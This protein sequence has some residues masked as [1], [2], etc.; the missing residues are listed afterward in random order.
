MPEEELLDRTHI[1]IAV[2]LNDGISLI[3]FHALVD[4]GATGYGFIDTVFV[5]DHNLPLYKLTIPCSLAVMDGHPIE[6]GTITHL[7]KLFMDINGHIDQIPIF[8]NKLSHYPLVLGVP[9]LH[10]HDINI[11]FSSN[12]LTFDS[13]F[14][15]THCCTT[16]TSI[17]GITIPFSER[18]V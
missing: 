4:C 16:T 15:L 14:F 18:I 1:V 12:T 13:N 10:R 2:E 6:S 11:T 7:N 17:K 5:L 9:W 8:V 3:P